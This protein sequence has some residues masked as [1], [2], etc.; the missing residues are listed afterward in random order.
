MFAVFTF[1]LLNTQ[2]HI[3][4]LT[5]ACY[6]YL[7]LSLNITTLGLFVFYSWFYDAEVFHCSTSR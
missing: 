6:C 4:T 2:L 3:G 1:K 7:S 5:V